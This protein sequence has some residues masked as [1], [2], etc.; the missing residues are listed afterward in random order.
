MSSLV[1]ILY[2][3]SVFGIARTL[4]LVV[5]LAMGSTFIHADMRRLV[6]QPVERMVT[7]VKEMA[8]DPLG[9]ATLNRN[10]RQQELQQQQFL[11]SADGAGSA[12]SGGLR[13]SMKGGMTFN[14]R[15]SEVSLTGAMQG[16]DV[17]FSGAGADMGKGGAGGKAWQ[18]QQQLVLVHAEAGIGSDAG[19]AAAGG[20][21]AVKASRLAAWAA[22]VQQS[23]VWRG[24]AA[25][26]KKVRYLS[27][28]VM[29]LFPLC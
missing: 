28:R 5:L 16:G 10:K 4:F 2:V 22:Q 17:R 8:E 20:W 18:Q 3:Q 14:S 7:R 1:S 26:L 24:T 9:Q 13:L 27:G 11:S 23:R 29:P 19:G 21:V 15:K 25:A 12:D 6:L